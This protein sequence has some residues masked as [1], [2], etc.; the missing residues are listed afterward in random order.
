MKDITPTPQNRYG[1]N[2]RLTPFTKISVYFATLIDDT[3]SLL[4]STILHDYMTSTSQPIKPS[5]SKDRSITY[6]AAAAAAAAV[7]ARPASSIFVIFAI[8]STPIVFTRRISVQDCNRL[9]HYEKRKH[10]QG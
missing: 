6:V 7:Y 3:L 5:R 8:Y 2:F 9:P 10:K 1:Y 4:A